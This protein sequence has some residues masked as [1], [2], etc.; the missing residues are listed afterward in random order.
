MTNRDELT[1]EP[2]QEGE[3]TMLELLL[4]LAAGRT[5]TEKEDA[6][7]WRR[8]EKPETKEQTEKAPDCRNGMIAESS[9]GTAE[10][11]GD[12]VF[13]YINRILK[14]RGYPTRA[15]TERDGCRALLFET[16]MAGM[17]TGSRVVCHYGNRGY[18]IEIVICKGLPART[19][20]AEFLVKTEKVAL[21]RGFLTADRENGDTRIIFSSSYRGGFSSTAFGRF[22]DELMLECSNLCREL[23]Q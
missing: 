8:K 23:P 12:A 22:F 10:E 4:K 6:I 2:L 18:T 13:D 17:R 16:Q 15:V 9:F 14:Q 20:L 7:I 11:Y 21:H 19:M 3:F 5:E 1:A